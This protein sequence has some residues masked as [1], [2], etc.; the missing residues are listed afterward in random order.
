[1]KKLRVTY[2]DSQEDV[3]PLGEDK[4]P[5]FADGMCWIYSI[6]ET[7]TGRIITTINATPVVYLPLYNIRKLVVFEED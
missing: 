2:M 4:S 6:T 5:S 1:M 3:Y 7:S